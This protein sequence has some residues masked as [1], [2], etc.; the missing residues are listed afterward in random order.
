MEGEREATNATGPSSRARFDDIA[1]RWSLLQGPPREGLDYLYRAYGRAI[2][3]Y[4]RARLA[5]G[6][7]SPLRGDDAEDLLQDFFLRLSTSEW[8]TKPDR[9]LGRFRPFLV[10]RLVFFLRERR[11]AA[12]GRPAVGTGEEAEAAIAHVAATDELEARFDREWRDA[13]VQECLHVLGK[14]NQNR[15]RALDAYLRRRDET[16]EDLA[17]ALGWSIDGFRSHLKRAR[18][19][20]RRLFEVEERRLDGRPTEES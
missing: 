14:R 12:L 8:L 13:T 7:F 18:A 2:L 1:T 19:E 10:R 11:S 5:R 16:D 17:A 4:V 3:S 9:R 6:D 20:F 15:R